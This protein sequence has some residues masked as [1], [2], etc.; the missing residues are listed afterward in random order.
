MINQN[1]EI[2]NAK[3]LQSVYEYQN[4]EEKSF[5]GYKYVSGKKL[6]FVT[7]LQAVRSPESITAQ[8]VIT[9]LKL[10]CEASDFY[11]Q[12]ICPHIRKM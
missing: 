10:L 2:L 12:E 4:L 6:P 11:S 3:L 7:A 5:L 1:S 9:A 8:D